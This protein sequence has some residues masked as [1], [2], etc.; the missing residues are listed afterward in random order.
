MVIEIIFFAAAETFRAAGEGPLGKAEDK[1]Y[2]G[3]LFDPLGLSKN[4]EA[5]AE[6]KVKEVKNG[7]LAM[8]A[9]LG[10]FVQA[11]LTREGPLDNWANHLADPATN[12]VFS[13]AP[14]LAMF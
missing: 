8:L 5:F 1:L 3:G 7:R 14:Q 9:M 13:V 6:F 10:F 11:G 4:A 2:P 12:T